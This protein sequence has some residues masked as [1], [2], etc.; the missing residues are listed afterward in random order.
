[1]VGALAAS[2]HASATYQA[3]PRARGLE[4]MNKF[5]RIRLLRHLG[6][7]TEDSVLIESPSDAERA[8]AFLSEHDSVSVRTFRPGNGRRGEP[9][10]PIVSHAEFESQCLPLLREGYSLIVARPID[11][12]NALVAG[13]IIRRNEDYLLELAFGSGTVRRVTHEGKIDQR[14]S[15]SGPEDPQATPLHSSA[16]RELATAERRWRQRILLLDVLYE[17]SV[18]RHPVGWK[19]QPTIFWE[20]EGL[21]AKDAELEAFYR[22]EVPS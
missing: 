14:L 16:L 17:F 5:D 10:F 4:A 15:L 20:I 1:M 2:H 13:C 6:L 21:D 8:G 18:Y 7:N 3:P 19:N 9:H 12:A 11:P 22:R